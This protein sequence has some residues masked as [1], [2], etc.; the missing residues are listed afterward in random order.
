MNAFEIYKNVFEKLDGLYFSDREKYDNFWILLG[1]MSP[2]IFSDSCSADPAWF[3]DFSKKLESK[4]KNNPT[5]QDGLD[6]IYEMILE[7]NN[8]SYNIKNFVEDY[9]KLYEL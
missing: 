6:V 1:Q 4:N 3:I 7:Y 8:E 2:D 5:V 9:K